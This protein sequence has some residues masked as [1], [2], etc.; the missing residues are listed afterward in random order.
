MIL[1]ETM[2]VTSLET[3]QE[4]TLGF[5]LGIVLQL[6]LETPQGFLLGIVL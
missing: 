4:T 5:L 6:I 3:L 1:Q 2:P